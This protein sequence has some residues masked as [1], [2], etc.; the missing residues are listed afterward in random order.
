M[1]NR[2]SDAHIDLF[3]RLTFF[4]ATQRRFGL[5]LWCRALGIESPKEEISGQDV[6]EMFGAGRYVDIARYCVRD[7]RA[8]AE[9]FMV[10]ETCV[11]SD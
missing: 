5:D 1:P 8:T 4:G 3:D 2:Y 7:V 11:R 10:W 6:G 9:L